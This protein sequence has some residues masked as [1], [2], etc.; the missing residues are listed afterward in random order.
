MA[1]EIYQVN[2]GASA[3]APSAP[4]S[5]LRKLLASTSG[6]A[7]PSALAALGLGLLLIVPFLTSISSKLLISQEIDKNVKYYYA[8][9]A[10][11]EYT[12]HHLKCTPLGEISGT[13]TISVPVGS[14]TIPITITNQGAE[15]GGNLVDAMLV[16]DYSGSMNDDG[17][18][19]WVGDYQP[20]GDAK[21]AAKAFV[22]I[23]E[24]ASAPGAYHYVG[25]VPYS[26]TVSLGHELTNQFQD[27][28]DKIDSIDIPV[29][30][31]DWRTNIGD[32]IAVATQELQ[33]P[34]TGHG[35]ENSV[36]A[37]VLLSD[38]EA[39]EPDP[40]PPDYLTPKE[41]AEKQA[42]DACTGTDGGIHFFTV[43][44]GT[45]VDKDLMQYIARSDKSHPDACEPNKMDFY[46]ESASSADL[47]WK[48]RSI[49]F[50]LSASKWDLTAATTGATV[51]GI[52]VEARAQVSRQLDRINII[53]WCI[54]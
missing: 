40:E 26:T 19:D 34:P 7:L 31:N 25:M 35:R 29:P 33:P 6:Q 23:L 2:V 10:A 52:K 15:A 51:G 24:E 28:K 41:Y 13:V 18:D 17:W 11:I 43:A 54:R 1:D 50:Y 49:A 8:A 38:G 37:I 44:L 3:D 16:M 45:E 39:N 12:L 42:D 30:G 21:S 22:D 20:I 46:Q 4:W 32:A 48:F 14:L 27:V 5:K 36:K 53:T 47:E 9:D